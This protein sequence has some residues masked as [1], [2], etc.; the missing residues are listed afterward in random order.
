MDGDC[1]DMAFCRRRPAGFSLLEM[2][3]VV[4]IIVLLLGISGTALMQRGSRSVPAGATLGSSLDLARSR[5]VAL[6]RT[7]WVTIA[8]DPEHPEDL[9]LRFFREDRPGAD[10]R[11]V[12]EFRR[13]VKLEQMILKSDLPPFG[14]RRRVAAKVPLTQGAT[15]TFRPTGEAHLSGGTGGFPEVPDTVEGLLE[16]GIQA[17]RGEPGRPVEKDFAAVQ[18]SGLSGQSIVHAP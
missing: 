5:A 7:V 10:D 16:I 3:V 13:P 9:E 11:P 4:A 14:D 17:T 8:P 6:N 12:S 18:L 2:L 1:M 15:V